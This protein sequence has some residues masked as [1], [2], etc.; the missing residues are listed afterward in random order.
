MSPGD[1]VRPYRIMGVDPG[2]TTGFAI[3]DYPGGVKPVSI[4][5]GELFIK[6]DVPNSLR[7][8]AEEWSPHVVV[9]EDTPKFTSGFR[10]MQQLHSLR[11]GI[12]MVFPFL[13]WIT[14][15]VW[16]IPPVLEM[17]SALG[18]GK[19]PHVRDAIGITLFWSMYRLGEPTN[20]LP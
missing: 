1:E 12:Q 11:S 5:L 18:A 14:P 3:L 15:G 2:V 20:D 19:G 6:D 13:S 8:L 4:F 7:L 17:A 9:V 16:K 10:D